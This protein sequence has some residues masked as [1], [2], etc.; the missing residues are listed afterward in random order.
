MTRL[1]KL[2][3]AFG[4]AAAFTKREAAQATKEYFAPVTATVRA[5]RRGAKYL[6]AKLRSNNS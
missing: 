2:R 6:S 1:N 4:E 5:A 3:K